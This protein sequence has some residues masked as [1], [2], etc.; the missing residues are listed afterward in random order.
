MN[1]NYVHMFRPNFVLHSIG[2]CYHCSGNSLE[3]VSVGVKRRIQ[4]KSD[5]FQ[6]IPLF[7]G[8]KSLLQNQEI[9]DEVFIGGIATANIRLKG[10]CILKGTIQQFAHALQFSIPVPSCTSTLGTLVSSSLCVFGLP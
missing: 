5:T 4:E 1:V 7:T 9:F 8:L 2:T 6:Y 3:A 10:P